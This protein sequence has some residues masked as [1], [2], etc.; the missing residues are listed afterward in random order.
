ME[1]NIGDAYSWAEKKKKQKYV[2][3][4]NELRQLL[5]KIPIYCRSYYDLLMSFKE[6]IDDYPLQ[7]HWKRIALELEK[8]CRIATFGLWRWITGKVDTSKEH[9]KILYGDT[10]KSCWDDFITVALL[11]PPVNQTYTVEFLVAPEGPYEVEMINA[12]KRELDFFLI[13]KGEENPWTYVEYHCGTAAN[14]YSNV[15]W[16]FFPKG[17]KKSVNKELNA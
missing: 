11:S 5:S 6:V 3:D 14:L 16:S 12:V 13:E 1:F 2:T 7:E 15:H 4:E 17:W 10:N 8:L 9:V